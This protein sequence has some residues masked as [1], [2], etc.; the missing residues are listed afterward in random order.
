MGHSLQLGELSVAW[1]KNTVYCLNARNHQ[2]EL[3]RI[4]SC[5]KGNAHIQDESDVLLALRDLVHEPLWKPAIEAIVTDVKGAGSHLCARANGADGCVGGHGLKLVG[6]DRKGR[7][8]RK[9]RQPLQRVKLL[10]V[11]CAQGKYQG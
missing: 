8:V 11:P 1:N 10:H 6:G 5:K 3:L 9:D 4:L 7:V 2:Q